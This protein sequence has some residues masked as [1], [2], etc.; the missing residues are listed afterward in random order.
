MKKTRFFLL[1]MMASACLTAS[2][3]T[4][5]REMDWVNVTVLHFA[6]SGNTDRS[7]ALQQYLL[8]DNVV[9]EQ[10]PELNEQLEVFREEYA[11][12]VMN[13]VVAYFP[14]GLCVSK[15][16]ENYGIVDHANTRVLIPMKYRNVWGSDD[17]TIMMSRFD[18]QLDVYDTNFKL[19]RTEP[20]PN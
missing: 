13:Q 10:H 12:R 20:A 18:E 8:L 17:D 11:Q 4:D 3:Q 19:I 5:E 2:A 7:N 15:D 9:A 16:G 6:A 1:A 14:F